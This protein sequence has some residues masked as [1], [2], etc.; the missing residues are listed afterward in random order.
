[1]L[2]GAFSIWV[3]WTIG[4]ALPASS[5]ASADP[6]AH[7]SG[8]PPASVQEKSPGSAT[9][10]QPPIEGPP[11]LVPRAREAQRALAPLKQGLMSTL[12][13]ALAEGPIAAV[14]ACR[15][16]APGIAEGAATEVYTVGRTSDRLRNPENAPAPW[17]VP[18]L[19]RYREAPADPSAGTVVALEGGRI[20]YVEPI[21]VKPLCTTCHGTSVDPALL[22]HIRERYPEDRATGYSVGD[23]RG[24]FFVV[25]TP[26]Q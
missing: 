17:M 14:D 13:A 12:Q 15:L 23:F 6:G 11:E 9:N 1:V 4:A 19:E 26:T 24:L 18:L 3:A 16:A 25:A 10:G 8:A 22:E 7:E 20:G 5:S 21:Y 2:I